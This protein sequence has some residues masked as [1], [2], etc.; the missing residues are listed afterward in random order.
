MPNVHSRPCLSLKRY[1]SYVATDILGPVLKQCIQCIRTH[2]EGIED[3][4]FTEARTLSANMLNVGP[5]VKGIHR[6]NILMNV[7]C[8]GMRK[9]W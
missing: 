6:R 2:L 4:P 8:K 3:N 9:V 1:D 7:E 5:L